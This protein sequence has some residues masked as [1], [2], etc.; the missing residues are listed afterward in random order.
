MEKVQK[1]EEE[2]NLF[3]TEMADQFEQLLHAKMEAEKARNELE[4]VWHFS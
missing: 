3:R 1:A 4:K 2:L